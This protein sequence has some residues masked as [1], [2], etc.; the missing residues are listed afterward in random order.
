MNTQRFLFLALLWPLLLLGSSGCGSSDQYVFTRPASA[1]NPNLPP[2]A[3]PDAY[4]SVGNAPLTI[5]AA[6]GLFANDQLNGGGLASFDSTGTEGGTVQVESDGSFTYTPPFGFTGAETFTYTISNDQGESSTTV[7][8]NIANLAFFVDNT[9][10]DGGNGSFDSRFNAMAQATAAAGPNDFIAVFRGDGTNQGLA[11]PIQLQD[12]QKLIGEGAGFTADSSL[13]QR[14]N[15]VRSQAIIPAGEPAVITGPVMLADG[16]LVAGFRIEGSDSDAIF[17]EAIDGATIEN[18]EI[19][20]YAE[21]GIEF[22]NSTGTL[23][24]LRCTIHPAGTS[25]DGILLKNTNASATVVINENTFAGGD[26]QGRYCAD[27]QLLDALSTLDLTCNNNRVLSG[28][29]D[30]TFGI[31]FL[32]NGVGTFQADGNEFSGNSNAGLL[33]FSLEDGGELEISLSNNQLIGGREIQLQAVDASQIKGEIRGNTVDNEGKLGEGIE[34]LTGEK[35]G[36]FPRVELSIVENTL[37]GANTGH[38]D[39]NSGDLQCGIPVSVLTGA[40]CNISIEGNVIQGF[41]HGVWYNTNTNA[42]SELSIV[43]NNISGA[44]FNGVLVSV[45]NPAQARNQLQTEISMNRVTGNGANGIEAV[46]GTSGAIKA[47]IL[48]NNATG[49]IGNDIRLATANTV[50]AYLCAAIRGNTCGDLVLFNNGHTFKV[51]S[52]AGLE[53]LNTITT[54]TKTG[55]LTAI[56]PD[57]CLT[58]PFPIL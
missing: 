32:C 40:T 41:R 19:L 1:P 43:N 3:N 50:G 58:D 10:P 13:L 4:P 21:S 52:L 9:A 30:W 47:A 14:S 26:V 48:G 7:T 2:Q 23:Q 46:A 33:A 5:P 28:M 42:P 8:I 34:I 29:G 16:N 55:I 35:N 22:L 44:E 49:N 20:G 27:I 15:E 18:N 25:R 57:D 31:S 51:E 17:G 37:I 36:R 11:G 45:P 12:G 38:T 53:D 54:L 24:V 56:D 39:A 6:A